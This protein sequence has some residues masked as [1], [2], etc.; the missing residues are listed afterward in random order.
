[1]NPRIPSTA[2][3][4]GEVSVLSPA[5]KKTPTESGGASGDK[6]V[7]RFFMHV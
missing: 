6:R 7:S 4:A 1:M 3:V 5:T 2:W